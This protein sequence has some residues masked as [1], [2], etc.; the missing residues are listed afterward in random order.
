VR[1]SDLQRRYYTATAA[2]YDE[3]HV[4]EQDE[5]FRALR[6]ISA[7]VP[8]AG[9]TSILDVG[10]GTGRALKPLQDSGV[11]AWGIEPV[12]ALVVEGAERKSLPRQ[13]FV[14]G[15]G[16]RL[17][18]QDGAFDATVAFAVFHHVRSPEPIVQEMMRVSRKAIFISD[19]NRFGRSGFASR[20]TKLLL[21]RLGLWKP[22]YLLRT[23]G[24][25]YQWSEGDG[26][27]YSYSVFDSYD[28]LARWAKTMV[29][30]PTKGGPASSS[31]SHPLLTSSH[32]LL[33]AFREEL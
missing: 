29:L 27:A 10:S 32:V 7:F 9:I 17:P 15:S 11:R 1:S 30:I 4:R 2:R 3:M 23:L 22:A 16:E 18:F 25:G 14:C 26:V 8:L 6:Y 20:L 21:Y 28:L 19:T 13:A 24:K 33:G 5:H 12:W 31:W